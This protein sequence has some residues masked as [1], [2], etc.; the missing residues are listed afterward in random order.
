MNGM[1]LLVDSY[2]NWKFKHDDSKAMAT[3]YGFFSHMDD[4]RF[5]HMIT[6]YVKSD[7]FNP[8]VAGLLECDT[9]PRKSIT[10]LRHEQEMREYEEQLRRERENA[11][12]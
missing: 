7:K 8:T 6:E 5:N 12:T 2:P 3:W 1:Q 9:L 11:R 4:E 10:Q